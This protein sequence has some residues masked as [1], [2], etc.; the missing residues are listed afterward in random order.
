M[1]LGSETK[2]W[3]LEVDNKD[4]ERGGVNKC[5]EAERSNHRGQKYNLGS[6]RRTKKSVM[7]AEYENFKKERWLSVR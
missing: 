7:V 2:A 6:C 5:G 1:K 3:D 4:R